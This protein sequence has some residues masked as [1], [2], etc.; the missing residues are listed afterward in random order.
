MGEFISK[1]RNNISEF[2]NGLEKGQKLR[3]I[4]AALLSFL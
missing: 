1:L 3:L 4:I 2:W